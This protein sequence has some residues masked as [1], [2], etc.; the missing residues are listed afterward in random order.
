MKKLPILKKLLLLVL[1]IPILSIAQEIK[2]ENFQKYFSLVDEIQLDTN[3]IFGLVNHLDI[4]SKG[5]YLVTDFRGDQVLMMNSEGK[6]LKSLSLDLCDPGAEMR[7]ILA[8]YDNDGEIILLNS[9]PWGFRF[10]KKGECLNEFDISFTPPQ[11]LTF[12]NKNKMVG[13]YTKPGQKDFV[14]VMTKNGKELYRFSFFPQKYTNIIGRVIGGG[15]II[16]DREIIIANIVEAKL[17]KCNIEGKLLETINIEPDYFRKIR[18]DIPL[19]PMKAIKRVKTIFK[20][21]TILTNLYLL[22]NSRILVEFRHK[23]K[24]FYDIY[25]LD[26]ELINKENIRRKNAIIL[27]KN[28]YVYVVEQPNMNEVGNLPNPIIKKYK[29]LEIE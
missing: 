24:V 14:K 25:N 3:I 8:K 17:Y 15:I 10:S 9:K 16:I 7:P 26:G 23:K 2:G 27:A 6:L 21:R 18:R 5:N 12:D 13:I 28:G 1:T 19:D 4:D 29:Y 11:R 20:E 22:T